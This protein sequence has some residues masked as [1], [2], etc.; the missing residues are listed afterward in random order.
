MI[1]E[2]IHN[3]SI[4]AQICLLLSIMLWL[5]R[6][7]SL[8]NEVKRLGPFLILTLIINVSAIY[9]SRNR[10][11]NLFLLHI[12]TLLE[13]L[14]WA[15]FYWYLFRKKQS[16]QKNFP[17]F[18]I[19]VSILIIA[20]TIVFESLNGFNSNSK[21]LVQLLLIGSAIFYFFNAFGKIDLNQPLPR[22]LT[23]I[24]FAVVFY[25][26]GSLFIFMFSR[27]LNNHQVIQTRQHV[28]W[29]INGML[30]LIFVILILLSLWTVAF[31]KTKSS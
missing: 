17:W 25:Y 10:I 30:Y 16:L 24:N 23:L 8:P 1:K 22:S 9:L 12:Y 6:F 31:R 26:S 2:L 27:L 5:W 13:F 19:I 4:T 11:P 7:K 29:A 3:L 18:V 15:F 28:L 21:S 20:N 14:A